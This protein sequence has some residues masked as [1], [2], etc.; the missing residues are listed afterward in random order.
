[1]RK[2]RPPFEPGCALKS[3]LF[4]KM[5]CCGVHFRLGA[6][7]CWCCG[8]SWLRPRV[9]CGIC[10]QAT[11]VDLMQLHMQCGHLDVLRLQYPAVF[12]SSYIFSVPFLALPHCA[13]LSA[14]S[15][16][17]INNTQKILLVQWQCVQ[18][19]GFKGG[20]IWNTYLLYTY[21]PPNAHPKP[22]QLKGMS[23]LSR[24]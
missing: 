2:W 9:S 6:R 1:M 3:L 16:W 20:L 8:R 13:S 24:Y 19:V 12:V 11:A 7:W 18:Q 14:F 21:E 17:V 5:A 10:R 4:A 23:Q 22:H 15:P